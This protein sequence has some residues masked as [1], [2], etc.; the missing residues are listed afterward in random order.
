MSLRGSVT[1]EL[2]SP[3]SV[4]NTF[5]RAVACL[6]EMKGLSLGDG[7]CALDDLPFFFF[8]PVKHSKCRSR[9]HHGKICFQV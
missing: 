8:F 2:L 5:S 4:I 9:L 6:A 1:Q 3:G 7:E